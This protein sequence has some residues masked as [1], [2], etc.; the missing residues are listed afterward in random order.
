MTAMPWAELIYVYLAAMLVAT[1]LGRRLIGGA[2]WPYCRTLLFGTLI[3]VLADAI[4]EERGLWTVPE[5]IGLFVLEVPLETVLLVL[6]TLMN[7]LLLYL[8]VS[9]RRSR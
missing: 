4:A 7:S 2:W 9:R 5:P 1:A 6:A 3:L 8:L